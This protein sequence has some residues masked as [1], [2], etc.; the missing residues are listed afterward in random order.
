M[1]ERQGLTQLRI[2]S[3]A[4]IAVAYALI[5]RLIVEI[6]VAPLG[7]V[8]ADKDSQNPEGLATCSIT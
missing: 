2:Y 6:T 3:A 8:K 5:E 1:L 7:T 4:T